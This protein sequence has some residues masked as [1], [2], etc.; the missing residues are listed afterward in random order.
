M[1]LV[2]QDQQP[3]PLKADAEG[4]IRVAQ[5]RV[6]LDTV[7]TAFKNGATAEQIAHDYPSVDRADIYAV[8][9]FYLH[10]RAGIEDYLAEQRDDA[11]RIR[12]EME[13]RFDP[14]G[15]RDRLVARRATKEWQDAS[16]AGQVRYLPL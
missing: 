15:I 1:T 10:H 5:T 7:V 9:A 13:A 12:E 14:H 3:V 8:I 2:L 16:T 6:S 4:V 11:K